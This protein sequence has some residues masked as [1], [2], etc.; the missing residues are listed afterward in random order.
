MAATAA[1]AQEAPA[2]KSY[3]D[4]RGG[5]VVLPLGDLSFAD[6][7]VS[8]TRGEPSAADQ[9]SIPEE[10]LGIPDY[11]TSVDDKYLTLG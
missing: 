5:E 9:H 3:P 10:A 4:G 8:F 11:S 2:A 1:Y 7:V 6:E